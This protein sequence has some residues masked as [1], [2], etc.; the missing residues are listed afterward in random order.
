MLQ[1]I[2]EFASAR[3]DESGEGH[4]V[5]HRHAVAYSEVIEAA[6]PRL[7]RSDRKRWLE[8]LDAEH[9]NLRAAFGHFVGAG[10]ADGALRLA[11]S[12]WRYWQIRGH[13]HE[14]RRRV[15]EA[16]ALEGGTAEHRAKAIEALGG[17]TWWQGDQE[18]CVAAYE[19]ALRAQRELGDEREVGN[20]LY[21]L[22][23]AASFFSGELDRGRSL[24]S[25]AMEIFVRLGDLEGQANVHWGFG[26][27][28]AITTDEL[29]EG[30][31]HLRRCIELYRRVGNVFGE[32]WGH[33]ELGETN[34]RL[35][36]S[37]EALEHLRRGLDLLY[38]SGEVSAATLFL[39]SF[40]AVAMERGDHERA[41]RLAGAAW[42]LVESSGVDLIS[43]EFNRVEGLD[44][45]S[46]EALD[47]HLADVYREGRGLSHEAAIS[48]ALEG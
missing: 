19:E 33:F 13:L 2:R 24:L 22:G 21:N 12:L 23:L 6:A 4:D 5:R 14:A 37:D 36:D 28:L 44:R 30:M 10:E 43:V 26:N 48:Y 45:E 15:D 47:G 38:G 11:W 17:I 27:L 42:G 46:L 9:D 3:L 1:V 35:G 20:A 7:T 32:G 29:R 8:E 39:M 41:V 31:E 16:L 18:A 40:A 25:E 34:R